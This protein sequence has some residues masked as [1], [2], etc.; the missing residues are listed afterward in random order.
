MSCLSWNCC[1]LRNPQTEDELVALVTKKDP[2]MVFLMETKVEKFVLERVGRKIQYPNLFV[3][4]RVNS[5]RGLALFWKSDFAVDMQSF[6]ANH[7]DV[8]INH[9]VD[10]ALRF[11]GFYGKPETTNRENSWSLLRSLCQRSSLPWVCLGDFNEILLVEEKQ[12]WLDR[13]EKQMQGFRD[14]L[15]DCQLKDLGFSGFPFTWCNR[16]PSNQIV[17]ARLDR[18]V[19]TIEWILRFS[20]IRIHHLNAF[21]SDHKPLL[22]AVDSELKRFYRKVQPFRFES[23]WLKESSYEEVVQKAWGVPIGTDSVWRFNEKIISCQDKLKNGT[24]RHLVMSKAL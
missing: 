16:H 3:V 4:L 24:R 14:A 5:G 23:M 17:W 21:H 8:I 6:S 1:G 11:T 22:L 9:V 7:S 20:A 15:D 10:D 12:G 18:G 2:K 19:A 13:P